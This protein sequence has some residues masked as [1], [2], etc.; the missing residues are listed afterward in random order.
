MIRRPPRSTRTDTLF[1]YTTLF[2]S[3]LD[4]KR[5]VFSHANAAKRELANSPLEPRMTAEALNGMFPDHNG[6]PAR[7]TFYIPDHFP[8]NPQPEILV[9]DPIDPAYIFDVII[10][11]EDGVKNYFAILAL[12]HEH[13]DSPHFL[14]ANPFIYARP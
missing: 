12:V 6:M 5:C 11:A 8:T 13:N 7:S 10:D 2:R 14:L 9:L 1:P 3:L 4:K